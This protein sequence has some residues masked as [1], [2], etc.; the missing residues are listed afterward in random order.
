MR[1]VSGSARTAMIL[2]VAL[3]VGFQHVTVMASVAVAASSEPDPGDAIVAV[4]DFA[5]T[6]SSVVVESGRSVTWMVR[7][8]PEQHTVTPVEPGAFEGSGQLFAGD[9]CTVRYDAPGRYEYLCTFHPFM[10]GTVVVEAAA[11][12]PTASPPPSPAV[13]DRSGDPGPAAA[14]VSTGQLADAAAGGTP[15][16][17]IAV[18]ALAVGAGLGAVLLLRRRPR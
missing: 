14:P 7:R 4:E 17:V 6:P 9:D 11:G 10:T 16:L 3:G 18:L 15:M 13:T 1:V 12:S 5:F 8:D 2:V